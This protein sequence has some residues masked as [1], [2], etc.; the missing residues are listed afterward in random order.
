MDLD[1]PIAKCGNCERYRKGI[2]VGASNN[3]SDGPSSYGPSFWSV[4]IRLPFLSILWSFFRRRK[5]ELVPF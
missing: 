3:L 2:G 4:R 1:K 5:A